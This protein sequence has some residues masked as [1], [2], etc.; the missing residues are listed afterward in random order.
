VHISLLG[1]SER[2]KWEKIN[3]Q[4]VVVTPYTNERGMDKLDMFFD[5]I[6]WVHLIVCK[7]HNGFDTNF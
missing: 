2:S 5:R 1:Y 6:N 4:T 7:L 3:I